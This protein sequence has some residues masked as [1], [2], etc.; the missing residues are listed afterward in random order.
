MHLQNPKS[1]IQNPRFSLALAIAI[2]TLTPPARAQGTRST[3]AYRRIKTELNAVPAIDTHD[4]LWPFDRLP[5]REK[6]RDGEQV[7]LCSIWR[8]S[9]LPQLARI[10]P[11]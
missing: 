9:Y 2:A 6:T 10:T 5:A 3:D 4:H 7:N 1:K 8:N 11:W